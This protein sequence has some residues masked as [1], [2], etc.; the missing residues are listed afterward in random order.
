MSRRNNREQ[1][2]TI[3]FR[4]SGMV[5]TASVMALSHK[6]AER[7]AEAFPNVIGVAKARGIYDRMVN[8]E[9]T[10]LTT[11]LIQDI[12][13]PKLSPL[14]MDEFIWLRRNKRR[15]NMNKDKKES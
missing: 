2:F 12:A 8:K 13:Q 14:A 5:K 9:L 6:R 4:S 3:R 1:I 15:E 10:Q 11:E 7:L